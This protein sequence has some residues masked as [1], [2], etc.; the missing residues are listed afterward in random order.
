MA[1]ACEEGADWVWVMDDDVAPAASC[2]AELLRWREHSECLQPRKVNPDGSEFP[3]EG[4]HDVKTGSGYSV[5]NLS[6]KNGKKIIYT[7]GGCFEGMLISRRIIDIVGFPDKKYFICNDDMLFALKASIHTSVAS[8][9]DAL[10]NKLVMP[11][12]SPAWKSYYFVRNTIFLHRDACEYFNI[13]LGF[14]ARFR[15]ILL[16]IVDAAGHARRGFR[17]VKPSIAGFVDGMRYLYNSKDGR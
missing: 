16:R 8:V 1:I 9:S 3:N 13:D 2:L 14:W 10:L 11:G 17:H 12:K 6:F 7:N 5:N 15:F 4:Y